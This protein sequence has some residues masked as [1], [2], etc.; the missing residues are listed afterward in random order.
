[1]SVITANSYD[2]ANL[3]TSDLKKLDN[4][5]SQVYL[6]YNGKRLRVQG[7]QLSLPY[8]SGDYNGNKKF[9]TT[10]SLKGADKNSKVAK[11]KAMLEAVDNYVIDVA[12]ANAGQWFKMPGAKRELIAAFFTPSVKIAKD[13]DGNPKDYPPTFAVKLAQRSGAFTTEMYDD[14]NS[15]IEGLTPVDVL[16]RGAEVV[17]IVDATGVWVGDK[18]FGVT[19]TLHQ[20]R[21]VV[22]GEGASSKGFLGVEDDEGGLTVSAADEE[23]M[24]AVMPSKAAAATAADEDED[25]DEEED[26]VVP[27]PPVPAKKAAAAPAPAPA[28]AAAT[29]TKKVVKR[30]AKA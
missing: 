6:N 1:M 29:V 21:V 2:S 4:G 27:A 3:T 5:S 7:P 18:K 14:K 25:E 24:A 15:V 16:R 23:L 22:P 13:K 8:D 11:F 9:K 17:P 26:D 28:P 20:V 10:L 12:T 30:V 19:W